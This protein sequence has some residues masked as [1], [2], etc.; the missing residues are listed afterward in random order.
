MVSLKHKEQ[1]RLWQKANPSK[2]SKI[3]KKWRE[4]NPEKCK[5]YDRQKYIKRKIHLTNLKINGCCMCGYKDNIEICQFHHIN[6]ELKKYSVGTAS[7]GRTD[8]VEEYHKC[9]LL[10]P[11]CH[12]LM[13]YKERE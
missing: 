8:F 7:M 10:C 12:A 2:V 13:H 6:P 1:I 4:A 5:E 9:M 3:N 11:N